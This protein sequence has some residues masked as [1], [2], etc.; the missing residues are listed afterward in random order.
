MNELFLLLHFKVNPGVYGSFQLTMKDLS[1]KLISKFPLRSC[2]D[3]KIISRTNIIW[4][5]IKIYNFSTYLK[6]T[7]FLS[8]LS[9][10]AYNSK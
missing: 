9:F 6:N 5:I 3:Y 7:P 8:T 4:N 10:F 2:R 1:K